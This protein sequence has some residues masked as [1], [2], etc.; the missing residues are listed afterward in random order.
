VA[1]TG[2]SGYHASHAQPAGLLACKDRE[3]RR[4]FCQIEALETLIYLAEAAIKAGDAHILNKL[5]A[6]LDAAG[7]SLPRLACKMATAT[8]KT[9]VM[10][11]I[12]AWHVLNKRRCPNDK[13]F[14]DAFL[15]VTPDITV[16]D[17]LRVLLPSDPNS[18]VQRG[19]EDRP[20]DARRSHAHGSRSYRR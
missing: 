9:F 17:R 13:R 2:L 7:T 18:Q 8:G 10:A 14:A 6:A 16:R 12:I 20:V 5:R 15:I 11:M 1:P 3:Q 4:F 19:I